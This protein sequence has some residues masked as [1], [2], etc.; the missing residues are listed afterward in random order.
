VTRSGD[1]DCVG[2][3]TIDR[4]PSKPR[5]VS[6][7]LR[8]SAPGRTTVLR[9]DNRP[10]IVT[11]TRGRLKALALYRFGRRRAMREERGSLLLDH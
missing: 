6:G 4:R 9:H 10:E 8:T 1:L 7:L 3:S 11:L 2:S 5:D